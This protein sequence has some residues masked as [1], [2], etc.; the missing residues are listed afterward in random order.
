[1]GQDLNKILTGKFNTIELINLIRNDDNLFKKLIS[2]AISDQPTTGWRAAWLITKIM[3]KKDKRIKKSVPKIIKA[4]KKSK[5]G[6][7]RELLKILR[8]MEV[9]E[10]YEGII[11]NTCLTIWE[12][13]NKSPSVRIMACKF[14]IEISKKY[15]DLK[16][17]I[18]YFTEDIFSENLSP[19]IKRVFNKL[20]RDI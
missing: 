10:R 16:N 4:I 1:M 11:F 18:E 13:I 5:D 12:D 3:E 14:V 19:G 6:H 9:G 15:P 8:N 17:E 7:Q 20:I 2:I